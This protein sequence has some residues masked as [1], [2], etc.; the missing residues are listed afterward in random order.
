MVECPKENLSQSEL[1]LLV[2]MAFKLLFDSFL[3]LG[4][5]IGRKIA[6]ILIRALLKLKASP[7]S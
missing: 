4:D 7:Q 5:Y 1:D 6:I 2:I 3:G